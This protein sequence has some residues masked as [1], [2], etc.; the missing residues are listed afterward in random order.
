[1]YRATVTLRSN[2]PY[3]CSRQHRTEFKEGESHEAYEQRTWR[4]KC[5]YHK[6][7]GEVFI[8]Q[9]AFKQAMDSSAK[10]LSIPDP[11]N[12]RATFTKNFLSDVICET[13]VYIGITKDKIKKQV[14]NANVDGVRGS[15]KRVERWLPQVSQW[16]GKTSFIIMD[17]RITQE[18][19]ERVLY[20][21]GSSIGVGQFR[22]EKGGMNGRFEIVGKIKYESLT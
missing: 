17:E 20:T 18:I 7:S 5:N 10:R 11:D 12:K 2:A 21:A 6:E 1:M 15:G 3:S 4:E 9:M 13:H 8:P 16:E 19:F 22:A 14:I